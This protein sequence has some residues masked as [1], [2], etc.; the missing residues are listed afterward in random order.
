MTQNNQT[1][2]TLQK[3]NFTV[4]WICFEIEIYLFHFKP[5]QMIHLT[6]TDPKY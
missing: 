3:E 2:Y 1:I 4:Y 6:R 5:E